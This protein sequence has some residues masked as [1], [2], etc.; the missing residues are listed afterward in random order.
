MQAMGAIRHDMIGF[1]FQNVPS[2]RDMKDRLRVGG[3][4]RKRSLTKSI[5]IQKHCIEPG[6]LLNTL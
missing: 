1:A 6:T 2:S 3:N 5:Q 4:E